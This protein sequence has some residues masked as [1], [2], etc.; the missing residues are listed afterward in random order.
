MLNQDQVILCGMMVLN[1]DQCDETLRQAFP[2]QAERQQLSMRALHLYDAYLGIVNAALEDSFD[3]M[4]M[5]AFKGFLA[6]ELDMV[7]QDRIATV[8]SV[9]D[10]LA[11]YDLIEERD[12]TFALSQ[13]ESFDSETYLA[14]R[15]LQARID[16]YNSWFR[17]AKGKGMHVDLTALDPHLSTSS[18]QFLREELGRYVAEKNKYDA[19]T[20][21]ELIIGILQGYV[22]EWPGR[23]LTAGSLSPTDTASF[24]AQITE[25]S[26]W[27]TAQSGLSKKDAKKNL[28]YISNVIRHFFIPSG[29]FASIGRP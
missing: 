26:N 22:S 9:S 3:P 12:I 27:Q 17:I 5:V 7:K 18:K 13:D 16:Y 10:L 14:K 1:A 23:E 21:V 20:D 11:Q 29:I 2:D 28:G 8:W 24:V 15:P 6:L 19:R 25:H 4:T